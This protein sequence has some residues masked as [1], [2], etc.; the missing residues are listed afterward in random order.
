MAARNA[1]RASMTIP[2]ITRRMLRNPRR[3]IQLGP[4]RR[5]PANP[6]GSKTL[7]PQPSRARGDRQEH[8][9][10][11]EA[12]RL[13]EQRN[14]RHHG[15][16]HY[17]PE[18]RQCGQTAPRARGTQAG[19]HVS[20]ISNSVSSSET[21]NSIFRLTSSGTFATKRRLSFWITMSLPE[22]SSSA[23]ERSRAPRGLPGQRRALL[24]FHQLHCPL[25]C[26]RRAVVGWGLEMPVSL[27][28]RRSPRRRR[29]AAARP[30]RLRSR[31]R[32]SRVRGTISWRPWR[33]RRRRA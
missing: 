32:R 23:I 14:D 1:I 3:E 19:V 6:R 28:V 12:A 2:A 17:R 9:S 26:C 20:S 7:A 29:A 16:R 33:S 8:Q 18:G 24:E 21:S 5:T 11:D 30:R 13:P 27:R 31:F 25:P 15:H 4:S 10:H 22:A